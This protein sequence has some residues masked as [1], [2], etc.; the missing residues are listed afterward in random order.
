MITLP[1]LKSIW[2]GNGWRLLTI[3]GGRRRRRCL[4][5]N[6]SVYFGY[7]LPEADAPGAPGCRRGSAALGAEPGRMASFSQHL[8][9]GQVRGQCRYPSRVSPHP[10]TCRK[11]QKKPGR[12]HHTRGTDVPGSQGSGWGRSPQSPRPCWDHHRHWQPWLGHQGLGDA[13]AGHIPF[14]PPWNPEGQSSL[15]FHPTEDPADLPYPPAP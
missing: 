5:E 15:T 1:Y 6:R 2:D 3:G 11:L 10:H 7:F 4:L 14:I 8:P 12:P 9:W 13:S